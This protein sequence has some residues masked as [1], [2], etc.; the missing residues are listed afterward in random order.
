LDQNLTA[1]QTDVELFR[2]K[3]AAGTMTDRKAVFRQKLHRWNG[4]QRLVCSPVMGDERQKE[5]QRGEEIGSSDDARNLS[6]NE[7]PSQ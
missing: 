1:V 7:P 6:T 5:K 4:W 2:F 3:A